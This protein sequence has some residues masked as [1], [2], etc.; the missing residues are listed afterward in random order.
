MHRGMRSTSTDR[1][2]AANGWNADGDVE[3]RQ[4]SKQPNPLPTLQRRPG[5]GRSAE[6]G[7]VP[8]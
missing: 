6:L 5:L 2:L 3:Q 1:K 7:P 8:F 4:Q